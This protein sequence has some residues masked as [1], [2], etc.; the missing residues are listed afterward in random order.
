MEQAPA[1]LGGLDYEVHGPA[2][3]R[4]AKAQ[5]LRWPKQRFGRAG[6][7]KLLS[8]LSRLDWRLHGRRHRWRDGDPDGGSVSGAAPGPVAGTAGPSRKGL[9]ECSAWGRSAQGE[10]SGH[11]EGPCMTW[12]F[13]H[14]PNDLGISVSMAL[15]LDKPLSQAFWWP[16]G[17]NSL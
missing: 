9:N 1:G 7:T 11:Q 2:V 12:L 17:F 5:S 3:Q 13:G 14:A 10:V 8:A 6:L 15:G 16:S 4:T